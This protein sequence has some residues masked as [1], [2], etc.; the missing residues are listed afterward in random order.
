MKSF[1]YF[2]SL[3]KIRNLDAYRVKTG[4]GKRIYCYRLE[5]ADDIN[6]ALTEVGSRPVICAA[7]G[8]M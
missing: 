1:L 5:D 2:E 6:L 3:K 4:R 7:G 8:R